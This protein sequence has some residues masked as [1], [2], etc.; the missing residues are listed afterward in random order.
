MRLT[1]RSIGHIPPTVG[2]NMKPHGHD[3]FH[4]LIVPLR[5]QLQADIRNQ[6]IIAAPGEALLYPLGEMHGEQA[7]GRE[8]LETLHVAWWSAP[9]KVRSWPLKG[10]DPHGRLEYLIRWMW[11]VNHL[12]HSQGD[13]QMKTLLAALLCAYESLAHPAEDELV[14]SVRKYAQSHLA[15]PLKLDD[16]AVEAGLS[17]YHFLRRFRQKAGQTPMQFLRTLRVQAARTLLMTTPLPLRA[18]AEHVGFADEY[19]LSRVFFEVTGERPSRMRRRASKP[20]K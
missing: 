4:E 5:G 7:L 13:T 14:A 11:D 2:W 16:L 18:I 1:F 8:P 15:Q 3:R 20:A 10:A 12:P 9:K 6:K 19:H 17:R